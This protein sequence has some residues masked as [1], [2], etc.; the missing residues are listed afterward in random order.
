[1]ALKVEAPDAFLYYCKE[2][3]SEQ[4]H[5]VAGPH[6]V[7][8][9]CGRKVP[10]SEIVVVYTTSE[11][12]RGNHVLLLPDRLLPMESRLERMFPPALG[13]PGF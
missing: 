9:A 13:G 5:T 6:A 8:S 11:D 1:M 3:D 4:W 2:T 12:W 10:G 7:C